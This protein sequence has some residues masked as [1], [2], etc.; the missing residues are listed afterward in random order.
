M[1]PYVV[2]GIQFASGGPATSTAPQLRVLPGRHN[3]PHGT[4][5]VW[6]VGPGEHAEAVLA[7]QEAGLVPDQDPIPLKFCQGT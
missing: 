2:G 5:A 4:C 7:E 3:H 6:D 1:I